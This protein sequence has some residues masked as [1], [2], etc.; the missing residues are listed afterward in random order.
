[1]NVLVS[2]CFILPTRY[3][4]TA[5]NK[6]EM[7]MIIELLKT[8]DITIIPVCPEQLGG[9]PTPRLPAEINGDKVIDINGNN[10]SDQFQLGA[11]STLNICN[12]V[13]I[14]F[15]VLKQ[16]IPSCGSKYIYDGSHTNTKISGLGVTA[17]CLKEHGIEVYSEQDF[18]LIKD[19]IWKLKI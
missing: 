18:D 16:G 4:G 12:L 1:M 13:N 15:A 14:E 6:P 10:L 9:L 17:K 5:Q 7:Q 8:H 19:R 2:S 3:D 11:T